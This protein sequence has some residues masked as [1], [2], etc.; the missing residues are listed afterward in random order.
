MPFEDPGFR[1][2][3][4]MSR[5]DAERH[6]YQQTRNPIHAW[7]AFSIC[8]QL[9]RQRLYG[10]DAL[11]D[12]LLD[13]VDSSMEG[14]RQLF[15]SAGGITP[16]QMAAGVADA[17]GFSAPGHGIRTASRNAAPGNRQQALARMVWNRRR[18][19]P[20]RSIES[21]AAQIEQRL[22]ASAALFEQG[23]QAGIIPASERPNEHEI[24]ASKKAIEDAW[25]EYH[26]VLEGECGTHS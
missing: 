14:L 1:E 19:D 2:G 13:Y 21:I 5:L 17:L 16:A 22:N 26:D 18:D 4:A 23:K 6:L 9:M 7:R 20:S 11:P 25:R 10:S 15:S 12:W 3:A 8:S 24:R